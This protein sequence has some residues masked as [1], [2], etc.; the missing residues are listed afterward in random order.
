MCYELWREQRKQAEAAERARR[1]AEAAIEKAKQSK[2]A[3]ARERRID[4]REPATSQ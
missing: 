3:P 4:R 1:E 2:P